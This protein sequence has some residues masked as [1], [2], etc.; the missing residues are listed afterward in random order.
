M[1]EERE[2]HMKAKNPPR[3]GRREWIGLAVLML[4]TLLIAM[5]LTVL[6]LA[7]PHL[8]AD[9]Q[10]STSELLW[11]TDI[12]GFM[13]AGS[14]ITMGT[15]GD[16]I[17]RR[18]LLL[19]G[20][21]AFGFASILAAF[22]TSAGML[23]AARALL[24]VAGAT[25]MPSTMSLIR[26]MFLNPNQRTVAIGIWV[27]GFSVG[28]AVGPLIGGLLLETLTWGSVFLLGV[29]VMAVLLIAGPL[30]LPEYKDPNPGKFDLLSAGMSLVAVLSVIYGLKQ[31]AQ[32]GLGWLPALFILAGLVIGFIFVQRQRRLADPLIDLRLF[33]VPAFSASLATYTLGIFAGFGTFLFIAQYLQSVLGL[34]P[35][36]AGLWS[37]PGAIAFVFGSN[38]A[39][40]LV[41]RI[42]PAFVVAGGLALAAVG[43]GLIT[44]IGVDSLA[45]VVAGNALMSLGFGFS[46]TLT[47]D[48]VVGAAPPERAGAASAM[49]ETGAELGGALGLA[50]L[51]SLGMAI[52]RTQVTA[53]MPAGVPVEVAQ[54]VKETL[55]GAVEAVAQLPDQVAAALLGSAQEAFAQALRTNAVIGVA[56]FVF[57]AL[58][59][60][61]MLR[62]IRPHAESET[63][64]ESEYVTE[65]LPLPRKPEAQVGD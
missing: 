3:A 6:H 51:G 56:G 28:S 62:H 4:P 32:D 47:V 63:E 50:V 65:N 14:L 17:G 54:A 5:D 23:I 26:N 55:G 46:F 39:P 53:A 24:G 12:Y 64:P 16:R 43:F 49:A 34:S 2:T 52:Y 36:Q 20:A 48:L 11:I 1:S 18:R 10:P 40:R 15:L 45:L 58:L 29:P 13:I 59:T 60:L 44:Q 9:L 31:V 22:S 7:V 21:A 19:M 57:L 25:L 61:T 35:L 33:R 41:R 38:L 30:L 42:R 8:S 27:S 37:V